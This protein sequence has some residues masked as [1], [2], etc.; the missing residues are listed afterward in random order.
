MK[1]KVFLF[2]LALVTVVLLSSCLFIP[3]TYKTF[4]DTT[5]PADNLTNVTFDGDFRIR[6]WNGTAI[7]T[8]NNI[9]LPAGNTNFLFNLHF[10]FSNDYSSTTY[11]FEDIELN[12]FFEAG[13]KYRIKAVSKSLGLFKGWEFHIELQELKKSNSI[14]LKEWVIGKS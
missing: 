3:K 14:L 2:V 8:S 12:Y 9:V 13:K 5:A 4:L 11:K 10:T 6:T 7:Y 1:N